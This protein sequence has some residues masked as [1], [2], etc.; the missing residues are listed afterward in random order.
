MEEEKAI[1]RLCVV[2]DDWGHPLRGPLVK[3]F[4]TS[5]LPRARRRQL[6]NH[7]LT[8]FL[9]RNLAI[10][11]KFSQRLDRQGVSAS[12]PDILKDNFCKIFVLYYIMLQ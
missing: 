6:G 11:S 7:R 4:E 2:L 1:L 9:N 12:D 5:L 8:R 3:A 10:V